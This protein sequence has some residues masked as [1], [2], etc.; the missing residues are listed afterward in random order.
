MLRSEINER[1]EIHQ[2][3]FEYALANHHK[4]LAKHS[5]ESAARS[6]TEAATHAAICAELRALVAALKEPTHDEG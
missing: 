4:A 1:L 6:L 5:F 3:M 2:E